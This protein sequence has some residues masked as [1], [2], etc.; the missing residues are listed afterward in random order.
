MTTRIKMKKTRC[1]CR[2]H[3]PHHSHY[4]V[5]SPRHSYRLAAPP[6][7][8][9]SAALPEHSCCQSSAGSSRARIFPPPPPPLSP[10]FLFCPP[11]R[12]ELLA[13][14]MPLLL[15]LLRPLFLPMTR[16]AVEAVPTNLARNSEAGEVVATVVPGMLLLLLLLLLLML[17]LM[18]LPAPAPAPDPLRP[19]L[20][21]R[22]LLRWG[23][24]RHLPRVAD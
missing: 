4:P 9:L 23:L 5:V 16:T 11:F 22:L 15:H 17:M 7:E 19:P 18:L 10:P 2:S 12:S 1:R 24:Y 21:L 13:P 14:L 8:R 3:H 20:L 6:L